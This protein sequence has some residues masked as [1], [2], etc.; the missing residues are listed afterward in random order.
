MNLKTDFKFHFEILKKNPPLYYGLVWSK[1]VVV[2]FG[3]LFLESNKRG[4]IGTFPNDRSRNL[5]P[6]NPLAPSRGCS[7][8]IRNTLLGVS[9]AINH[10]NN[11]E[12]TIITFN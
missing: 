5:S 9:L 10:V 11:D 12:I 8:Y 3:I 4:K 2:T 7:L 6:L 1:N